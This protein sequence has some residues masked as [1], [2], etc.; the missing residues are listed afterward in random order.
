LTTSRIASYNECRYLETSERE[1]KPAAGFMD[2]IKLPSHSFQ[3][4]L[5]AAMKEL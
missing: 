3:L 2:F 4:N 5:L 1:V